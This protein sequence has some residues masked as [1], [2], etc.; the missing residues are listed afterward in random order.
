MIAG[1]F[2]ILDECD[3]DDWMFYIVTRLQLLAYLLDN[4]SLWILQ[5]VVF[6]S[7]S[8]QAEAT[9]TADWLHLVMHVSLPKLFGENK[10][11]KSWSDSFWNEL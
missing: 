6:F 7:E 5:M 11:D 8:K 4:T 2:E 9:R 3:A 10:R 1:D